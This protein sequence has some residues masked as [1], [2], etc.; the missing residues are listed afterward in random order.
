MKTLK[1][2]LVLVLIN[3]TD[4]CEVQYDKELQM[5]HIKTATVTNITDSSATSGGFL[6]ETFQVL[7]P[8]TQTTYPLMDR[9]VC[10]SLNSY[11]IAS[12]DSKT[13]DQNVKGKDYFVSQITG[14]LPD[15]TYY[16]KAYYTAKTYDNFGNISPFYGS[17]EIIFF[18]T[19]P[20]NK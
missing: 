2:F 14:L 5:P 4:S 17:G 9:G 1:V 20:K 15:T 12:Q 6:V 10:W 3:F 13:I 19:L 11:P 16:V 7:N 18:R 8:N